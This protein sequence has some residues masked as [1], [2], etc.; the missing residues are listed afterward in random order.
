[1][2]VRVRFAPSPTGY[3]HVGGA[4]TAL[5]N[6]LH[7]RASGGTFVLRIEDT[8]AARS[9]QDSVQ[10]IFDAMTWLGLTWDEG[11]G[12][13]GPYGPYFQSERR[14]FYE[15]H[16]QA[17]LAAGRA[18]PCYCTAE[19]LEDR[20]ARQLERG[21]S[22]RYDGRCR[23]L[24]AGD[25]RAREAEGRTS[26]LRFALVPGPEVAWDDVVRERVAF[27]REVL[28]DFVLVRS[29][30]L[31]TYNYACVVDD[32]E[33]A[34]TDVV[35]GD[36]HISN[37]PR[38]LLLYE[39]FGWTPPAFA[40]VPMILGADGT[41]LSK[42]HG[43]T[44]AE[45][46]RDLGF[47]PEA[48]VNFLA[49]LGWSYDGQ[50][51]MFTLA[52][53]EQVF[54]LDRVG[55]NPA[56]FN[57]EKL[58]WMNGQHL[59][60]LSEEERVRRVTAFLAARGHDVARHD[61]GW[62]TMLVRAIGDRMKTLLDAERHGRFALE[63]ALEMDENAWEEARQKPEAA[64]RWAA[65]AGMLEMVEPYDLE[66]LERE[67]RALAAALGMKAGELIALARVALTGRKVSPGIFDVMMLLGRQR[68]VERLHAAASRASTV[69]SGGS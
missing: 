59:R 57:L 67:T 28:D 18:Y 41:R 1:L 12:V 51:E 64:G 65:L 31:P 47:L 62:W 17:L 30:G 6:A 36:D 49:L 9:T 34:I 3:L 54:R 68:A 39:A 29:D 27:Q 15:R 16:A 23:S 25:R 11:P 2:S 69:E 63:D 53:L 61:A 5:F 22:P 66:T 4:R 20:R 55:S 50:R 44:S 32:H 26:A 46:F 60:R 24:S 13:G 43:A 37:T 48:M 42:R 40:H 52:E 33:M 56:V 45:A 19:E 21:E 38:Q 14:P 7:A 8:D 35:R 58:E 10:A